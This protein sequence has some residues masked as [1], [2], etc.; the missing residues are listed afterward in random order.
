M[1]FLRVLKRD[2][3]ESLKSLRSDVGTNPRFLI[4]PEDKRQPAQPSADIGLM[5]WISGG[6][7]HSSARD[8]IS[9]ASRQ[10]EQTV[11]SWHSCP[12]PRALPSFPP[13]N[14]ALRKQCGMVGR[15][16][17]IGFATFWLG[18]LETTTSSS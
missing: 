17:Q 3:V 13:G 15:D 1:L 18:D 7:L 4:G 16:G 10:F 9:C 8:E 2:T 5:L 12:T 14:G 6:N 11:S